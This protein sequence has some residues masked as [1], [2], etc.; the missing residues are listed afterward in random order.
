MRSRFR[1]LVPLLLIGSAM[2]SSARAT[3]ALSHAIASDGNPGPGDQNV[4]NIGDVASAAS[5]DNGSAYSSAYANIASGRSGGFVVSAPVVGSVAYAQAN[6]SETL[7]F[8]IA[9]GNDDSVTPVRFVFDLHGINVF[10]D[11]GGYYTVYQAMVSAS[12][13]QSSSAYYSHVL[14]NYIENREQSDGWGFSSLGF[15]GNSRL[16]VGQFLLYGAEQ[17][18]SLATSL[19]LLA[20]GGASLDYSHTASIGLEVPDNV[21]WTSSSGLFLTAAAVPEPATWVMLLVG[22]GLTGATLRRTARA[23]RLSLLAS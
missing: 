23:S 16:F 18:V 12:G 5:A 13:I 14:S 2:P 22:F 10:P 8:S 6:L 17:D 19:A 3:Q 15:S 20:A 9:G 1:V 4:L 11:T 7:H 21:T